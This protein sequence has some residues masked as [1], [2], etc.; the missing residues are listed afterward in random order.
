MCSVL[1]SAFT[2]AG[3]D[4]GGFGDSV[5]IGKGEFPGGVVFEAFC[6]DCDVE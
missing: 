4:D 6:G 3:K 5:H 1:W 2:S